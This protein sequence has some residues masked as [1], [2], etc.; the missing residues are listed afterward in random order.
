MAN[1]FGIE[2]WLTLTL[3]DGVGSKTMQ[4]LLNHYGSPYA[5]VKAPMSDLRRF[6]PEKAANDIINGTNAAA[7]SATIKWQ[8]EEGNSII[9][10]ADSHYPQMLLEIADPPAL[11][12]AR[13]DVALLSLPAVAVV[14][15]RNASAAGIRNTEI[16][17][18]AL[19]AAGCC[20]VS[21]LA[22]GVDT[23]AH[24]GAL[25]AGATIAVIGTGADIV[26]PRENRS[27]AQQVNNQ[28]LMLSEFALGT[29]PL[30]GNFPRRNRIISGLARAC[31]VVEATLKS[32]SLITAKL[33]AEYGRDVFAVPGSINSPLHRGCH[34][35]IRQGAK[36]AENVKDI[37]DDLNIDIPQ[38]S[39]AARY[40]ESRTAGAQT[41]DSSVLTYINY[42][43]TSIDDI[44]MRSGTSAE[45]L[46]P[47]LLEL[48]IVG[49][50]VATAGGG[51]QRV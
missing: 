14:G 28:G 26:Y 40:E 21:G 20:I 30:A 2:H 49:K 31:L 1:T 23:A 18:R 33:A 4:A 5:A 36:L 50:I 45:A 17:A 3:A 37:L 12:Y 34:Q 32:G 24:R 6:V 47:A 13:G 7:I 39:D 38:Q 22:Q 43:P 8:Q 11:L 41:A 10:L 46:L 48:E 51:Y 19:A 9:T 15:S 35:L 29:K 42:Q 44:A 16:F 25:V 27:L